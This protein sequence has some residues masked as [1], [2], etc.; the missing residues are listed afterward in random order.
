MPKGWN[1][2]SDST[3]IEKISQDIKKEEEEIQ[4]QKLISNEIDAHRSKLTQLV[5]HRKEYEQKVTKEK[6]NT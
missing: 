4:K 5:S 6:S 3:E 1:S 2:L